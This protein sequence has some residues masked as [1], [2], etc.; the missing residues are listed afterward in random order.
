MIISLWGGFLSGGLQYWLNKSDS[1]FSSV[2][3]INN[4]NHNWW[5]KCNI[6]YDVFIFSVK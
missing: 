2:Y 1:D 5:V 3:F 6:V 4:G